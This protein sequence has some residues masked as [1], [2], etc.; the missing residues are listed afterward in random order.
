[1]AIDTRKERIMS[2][3]K[4][5]NIPQISREQRIKLR[6]ERYIKG[7]L[8]LD[9]FASLERLD[10]TAE[11]P[12]VEAII[13]KNKVQAERLREIHQ[14]EQAKEKALEA[15]RAAKRKKLKITK[16]EFDKLRLNE[17]QALY[18]EHP[19]EVKALIGKG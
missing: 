12:G 3:N 10:E 4:Q 15:A 14:E 8:S 18:N 17:Q 2:N 7:E 1:M 9:E 5:N 6:A 11:E 16:E 19:D 13:K